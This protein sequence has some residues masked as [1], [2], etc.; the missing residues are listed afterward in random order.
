[1]AGMKQVQDSN[2]THH[3]IKELNYLIGSDGTVKVA[4]FG[5]AQAA[6]AQGKVPGSGFEFTPA[7]AA[8]EVLGK[9]SQIT[10]KA[11]TFSLGVMLNNLTSPVGGYDKFGEDKRVGQAVTAVDKLKN[12]MLDD[13]PNKR[14]TLEAVM[15]TAFMTDAS[16]NYAPEQIDNLMKALLN[17]NKNVAG[18]TKKDMN[19]LVQEQGYMAGLELQKKG[20][21]PDQIKGLDAKIAKSREDIKKFQ[22]NIDAILAQHDIK[23]HVEALAKAN[24]ELTG[25]GAQAEQI[26][27]SKLKFKDEFE[28]IVLTSGFPADSKPLQVLLQNLIVVDQAG[29]PATKKKLAATAEAE[30][31][32]LAQQLSD[33]AKLATTPDK[34]KMQLSKLGVDLR[35]LEQALKT[36]NPDP[37]KVAAT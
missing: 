21:T 14:P 6:D 33:V 30:A 9:E 17:Y 29:D 4:D 20:A 36:F 25:R 34:T 8:P 35:K 26:D 19:L 2:M 7:W 23:P 15:Q 11:D 3:D 12:A 18:K 16:A 24:R 31:K 28:K 13:D 1:M 22:Q 32:R 37:A 27:V 5:S 10:G